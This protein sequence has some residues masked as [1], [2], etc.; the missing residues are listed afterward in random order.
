MFAQTL[1][2]ARDRELFPRL[3]RVNLFVKGFEG[4]DR[5]V[6]MGEKLSQLL[7][8]NDVDARRSSRLCGRWIPH[9]GEKVPCPSAEVGHGPLR[10][11]AECL[12]F[13]GEHVARFENHS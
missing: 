5:S 11:T 8:G 6:L 7:R 12:N 2:R 13:S 10:R 1:R 9:E 4:D 3:E